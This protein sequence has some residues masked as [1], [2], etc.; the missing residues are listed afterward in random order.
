MFLRQELS[1]TRVPPVRLPAC[2][3]HFGWPGYDS[4]CRTRKQREGY[5]GVELCYHRRSDAF[6]TT[7]SFHR[8]ERTEG[9]TV[10]NDASGERGSDVPETFYFL[11]G[12][13]VQVHRPGRLRRCLLLRVSLWLPETR[14]ASRIGSLYLGFESRPRPRIGWRT[15]VECAEG[16]SRSPEGEHYREKEERLALSGGRHDPTLAMDG[17]ATSPKRRDSEHTRSSSR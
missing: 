3:W 17:L 13:D 7:K 16:A 1:R 15:A 4:V 11:L 12:R 2:F 9:V 5:R 6:Y 14:K 10:G 8:A